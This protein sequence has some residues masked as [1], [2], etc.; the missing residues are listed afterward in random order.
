MLLAAGRT[1]S[2]SNIEY[3]LFPIPF[4]GSVGW[5][6]ARLAAFFVSRDCPD[7]Q[8]RRK[9]QAMIFR[10][11]AWNKRSTYTFESVTGE[12]F[13]MRPGEN[14]VT[15]ADIKWLH[16]SRDAEVNNNLDNHRAPL[17]AEEKEY[18]RKWMA[19]HPGEKFPTKWHY[20]LDHM[21]YDDNDNDDIDKSHILSEACEEPVY[22]SEEESMDELL[23]KHL[24]FLTPLQRRV[25]YLRKGEEY[26]GKEVAKMLDV[27]EANVS[28]HY[29]KA[30]ARIEEMKKSL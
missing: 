13:V 21:G 14:D 28:K 8:I 25:F 20:S 19:E 22:P 17:T 26:T 6:L 15:E 11:T 7:R 12:K 10:K 9:G 18:K 30:L 3:P 4:S 16:A 2:K 29:Q 1:L 5:V 24:S 27:S 23:E